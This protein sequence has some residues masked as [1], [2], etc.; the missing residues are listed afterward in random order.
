MN[1]K[2]KK[3]IRYR[4]GNN[5]FYKIDH[6]LKISR[7]KIKEIIN[8]KK[9]DGGTEYLIEYDY[10]LNLINPLSWVFIVIAILGGII[11]VGKTI[12]DDLKMTTYKEQIRIKDKE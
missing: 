4:H 8:Q 11:E 6:C 12:I 9:I 2:I 1:N 7:I 10:G 3:I 5:S